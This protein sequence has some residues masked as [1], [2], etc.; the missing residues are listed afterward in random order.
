VL[1]LL[2]PLVGSLALAAAVTVVWWPRRHPARLRRILVNFAD[3]GTDAIRGVLRAQAGAWLVVAQA[4]I[5]REDGA[6]LRL[7]GEII[8]ER[9]AVLFLQ[10]LP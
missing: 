3:P 10:V 7:D 5:V 4:E 8:V 9:A 6:T 2:F 1:D